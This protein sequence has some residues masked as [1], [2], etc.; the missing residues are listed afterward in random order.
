MPNRD[1]WPEDEKAVYV[2]A[3]DRYG[4]TLAVKILE[5]RTIRGPTVSTL[6]KWLV[7]GDIV[8]TDEAFKVVADMEA[9][10]GRNWRAAFASVRDVLFKAIVETVKAG[11]GLKTQQFMTSAG[12]AYDKIVPP[13]RAVG[14]GGINTI[15]GPGGK[16]NITLM[17][18]AAV[19]PEDYP[20]FPDPKA[21]N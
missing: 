16:V 3:A 15:V 6:K 9:E 14:A 20:D 13:V 21:S 10:Q 1:A 2:A 11:E 7:K 5:G 17:A 18:P 4:P 12:I 19:D 8:V